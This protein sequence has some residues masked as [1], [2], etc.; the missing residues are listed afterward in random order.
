MPLL[1]RRLDEAWHQEQF[2]LDVAPGD[3][4]DFSLPAGTTF[5]SSPA[6]PPASRRMHPKKTPFP[7]AP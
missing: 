3:P 5:T 6:P 4:E 7:P 2:L 1:D